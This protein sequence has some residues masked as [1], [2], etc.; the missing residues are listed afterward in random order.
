M[1]P[2][3]HCIHSCKDARGIQRGHPHEPMVKKS[4]FRGVR[5]SPWGRFAAE[6]RDPWKKTRRWLGTFDTAE[7]AACAYDDAA[8]SLRGPK[9]KTNFY[10]GVAPDNNITV[11]SLRPLVMRKH[12]VFCSKL[13]HWIIPPFLDAETS[14]RTSPRCREATVETPVPSRSECTGYKLDALDVVMAAKEKKTKKKPFLF[15]LNMQAPL[16]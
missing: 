12:D 1:V 4:H 7:E 3:S 6:I 10:Y 16:F 8:R 5:K 14:G 13:P 15:D 9:A 2:K 11:S